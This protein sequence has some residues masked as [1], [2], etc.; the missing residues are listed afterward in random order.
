MHIPQGQ[1]NVTLFHNHKN[2]VFDSELTVV[3]GNSQSNQWTSEFSFFF[4]KSYSRFN[5]IIF[6]VS[7]AD[8]SAPCCT[9][10]SPARGHERVKSVV[11]TL[12][13]V[14]WPQLPS[15]GGMVVPVLACLHATLV[16][17][18][19]PGTMSPWESGSLSQLTDLLMHHG[20]SGVHPSLPPSLWDWSRS[21]A[22]REL[23]PSSFHLWT[24]YKFP[25]SCGKP[26]SGIRPLLL[27]CHGFLP[28]WSDPSRRISSSFP[29]YF[30]NLPC[31][32]TI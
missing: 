14:P 31:I 15:I 1:K 21:Q 27:S 4:L 28:S 16:S 25:S 20:P 17:L 30:L 11:L 23:L 8:G 29:P 13:S 3:L 12:F 5:S 26:P 22:P 18:Q 19:L 9:S 7:S 2:C 10:Q 6:D 24:T 32:G